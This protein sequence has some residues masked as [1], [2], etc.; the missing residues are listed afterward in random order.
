MQ[1]ILVTD[2]PQSWKFL[3]HLAPIVSAE[4]YLMDDYYHQNQSL[5]IINLCQSYHY[6]TIGYYVSLLAQAR[7]HKTIPSLLIFKMH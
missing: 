3:S 5:R 7:D 6:Q 2:V 1:T 4:D